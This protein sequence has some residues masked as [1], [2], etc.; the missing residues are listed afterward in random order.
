MNNKYFIDTEFLQGP[1]KRSFG[2]MTKPTIDLISIGIIGEDGRT[3]Y[4]ICKEFNVKEAWN[5][6]QNEDRATLAGRY[7]EKVYWLRENVLKQIH[8]QLLKLEVKY[9]SNQRRHIGFSLDIDKRFTYKNFKRL[10]LKYGN[11]K[12]EINMN[13]GSIK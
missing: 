9:I 7:I 5:R 10:L 13:Y 4:G 8:E 1:Q 11:T 12:K 3:Y 2:R 6:Y